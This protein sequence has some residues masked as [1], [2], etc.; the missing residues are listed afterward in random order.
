MNGALARFYRS[1]AT[2]ALSVAAIV[3]VAYVAG[4]RINTT[5]SIRPGLYF[6]TDSPVEKGSYVF[7]CPPDT[8][9]F[10]MA[11]K[12]GYIAKGFCPGEYSY[13]MKRV[14]AAKGDSVKVTDDGVFV[15]GHLLPYSKPRQ[16]DLGGRELPRY[17]LDEYEVAGN[18]LLLMS[19]VS[20]TSFDARY[21]G[22]VSSSQVKSV[23]LPV[24]T[25]E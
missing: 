20:D 17:R 14:L 16:V 23:I 18:E 19:D 22:L 25:W 21:F 7:F 3:V 13:M 8:S 1:V 4:F 2:A 11:K 24:L 9:V 5:N 10:A 12:H 15:E 6:M